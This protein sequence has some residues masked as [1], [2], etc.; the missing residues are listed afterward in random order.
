MQ[1]TLVALAVL[2]ASGAAMAQSSVTLFGTV[3]AA[4]TIY[5]GKDRVSGLGNS[6]LS[7][8]A[9]GFRGVEDLGGGAKAEF[10]LE[11]AVGNDDGSG[12]GG[13]ATSGAFEFKR[14][15][16]LSLHANWGEFRMGRYLTAAYQ[17][18]SRYDPFGTNGV[19]ASRVWAQGG[20]DV[21]RSNMVGYY[22]PN[23][24]GFK[25]AVN[26]AFGEQGDT[27]A[28]SYLG[29]ALTYDNGPLSIG[30][31]VE[32]FKTLVST[33]YVLGGQT[34]TAVSDDTTAYQ[35]G[36]SYQFGTMKLSAAYLNQ[37][38][39]Y[40]AAVSNFNREYDNFLLGLTA[41][42]GATG[43]VKVSYNR[44]DEDRT[45]AKADQFALGYVQD[46]SKR[47]AVY[48]TYAYIKNKNNGGSFALGGAGLT[49]GS[50]VAN[51][52]NGKMHGIQ[53]GVRHNF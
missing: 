25:L 42:V 14:R 17:S 19:G 21:R 35:L 45:G 24:S 23:W 29:G 46:L 36:A 18:A 34:Y 9:L 13:G 12:I 27:D 33:P 32:Q 2:A 28:G 11:G 26:T 4:V 52:D 8:S 16:S 10:W 7:S 31:G 49:K 47:T 6:G 3:D 38:T 37:E 41:Q 1:K 5:D 20:Y 48:G 30:F 15:S 40:P 51:L 43:T 50:G 22:S 53:V 39:K 44:Y